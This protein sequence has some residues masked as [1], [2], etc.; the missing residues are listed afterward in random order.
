MQSWAYDPAGRVASV[1]DEPIS[2]CRAS[3]QPLDRLSTQPVGGQL[4]GI[5]PGGHSW[6]CIAAPFG[7]GAW[8]GV[9]L[10]VVGAVN[11]QVVVVPAGGQVKALPLGVVQVF[12]GRAP[13]R[14]RAWR[15]RN[16][17]PS[18]TTTLL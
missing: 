18:V 3:Y 5:D 10:S 7:D 13:P 17:S 4:T 1:T 12:L 14:F 8:W 11:G 15:M 2:P 16:D 6:F 9:R